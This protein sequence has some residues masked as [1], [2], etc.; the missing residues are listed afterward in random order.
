MQ[1]RFFF[2]SQRSKSR[3]KR[4]KKWLVLLHAWLWQKLPLRYSYR[5]S[6]H[7]SHR[8]P[9]SVPT[10]P[11]T[12]D[13]NA[14]TSHRALW[15]WPSP[16]RPPLRA[17]ASGRLRNSP[18]APSLPSHLE[19]ARSRANQG[20]GSRTLKIKLNVKCFCATSAASPLVSTHIKYCMYIFFTSRRIKNG[21]F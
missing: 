11:D 18:Q 2:I 19:R 8:Q 15:S 10:R 14:S 9:R 7:S 13:L 17:G 1:R 20:R 6:T 16:P 4:E 21:E 12:F 5:S 3:A